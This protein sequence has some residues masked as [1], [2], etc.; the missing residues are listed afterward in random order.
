MAEMCSNGAESAEGCPNY[1]Q[2]F[3][4]TAAARLICKLRQSFAA[5]WDR[6][7]PELGRSLP[8]FDTD[9]RVRRTE[10]R[11][12][13]FKLHLAEMHGLRA[14]GATSW[15]RP[16]VHAAST[17]SSAPLHAMSNRSRT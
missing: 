4:A 3:N 1:E 2:T 9:S 13:H 5:E 12:T 8:K 6:L 15:P 14:G 10:S 16:V 11:Q 7:W 17:S